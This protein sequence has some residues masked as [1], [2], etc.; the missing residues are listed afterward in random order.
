MYSYDWQTCA[1]IQ[2]FLALTLYVSLV[3]ASIFGLGGYLLLRC[4]SLCAA[5]YEQQWVIQ[6]PH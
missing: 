5:E 6:N 3:L 1:S 2:E 4:T